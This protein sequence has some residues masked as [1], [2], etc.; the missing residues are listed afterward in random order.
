VSTPRFTISISVQ[1][2]PTMG[3][4]TPPTLRHIVVFKSEP[5]I[6]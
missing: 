5:Y 1:A 4:I 6:N 2:Y 3:A